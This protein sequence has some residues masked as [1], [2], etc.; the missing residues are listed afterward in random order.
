[1]SRDLHPGN[2]L[3]RRGDGGELNRDVAADEVRGKLQLILLDFGLAEELNPTV[4]KHF[5]SFLHM[6]AAGE[7]LFHESHPTPHP[8]ANLLRNL[9]PYGYACE[10]VARRRRMTRHGAKVSMFKLVVIHPVIDTITAFWG[11]SAL[12]SVVHTC[13]KDVKQ[14]A[15][16]QTFKPIHHCNHVLTLSSFRTSAVY[17]NLL[18]DEVS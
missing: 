6:I 5:I 17:E 2:I 8:F 4:R 11:P 13:C 3:V 9:F 18:E 7:A 14:T 12:W 10:I 16:A 1:M 15:T